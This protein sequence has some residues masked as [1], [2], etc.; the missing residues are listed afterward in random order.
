MVRVHVLRLVLSNAPVLC[1]PPFEIGLT[2]MQEH[3]KDR[4]LVKG[5]RRM[6][7]H[8][9]RTDNQ[10]ESTRTGALQRQADQRSSQNTSAANLQCSTAMAVMGSSPGTS[11]SMGSLDGSSGSSAIS[12]I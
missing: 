9:S 1:V 11:S 8:A 12:G 5:D 2:K 10:G 4:W 3:D 7:P 6:S